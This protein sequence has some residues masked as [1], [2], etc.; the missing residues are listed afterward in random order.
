VG[1]LIIYFSNIARIAIITIA[2]I[3]Y[4]EYNDILHDFVFPSIIYGVTFLL[5]FI[6]VQKFSRL[7]K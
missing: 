2:L 5:W 4:P 7:S 6:W 1:S 3:E